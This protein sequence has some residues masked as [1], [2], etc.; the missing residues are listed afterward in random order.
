MHIEHVELKRFKRF[1]DLTV[2]VP[3]GTRLVM[4][5]GPNGCGKSSLFEA[6]RFRHRASAGL[7][8]NWDLTYFPKAGEA[9]ATQFTWDSSIRIQFDKAEPS[10]QEH[11]RKM[12]YIRSAYE[13]I[14]SSLLSPLLVRAK[15]LTN[16]GSS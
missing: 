4:L 1:H 10:D 7:G 16:S 12:F 14:P 9:D 5:A 3:K 8:S 15:P 2:E 6:F 11:R 13:T